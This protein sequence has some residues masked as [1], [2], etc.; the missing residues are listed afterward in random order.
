MKRSILFLTLLALLL[1][2][3]VFAHHAAEG[4]V[5][6]AIWAMIDDNLEGSPHLDLDFDDPGCSADMY[7]CMGTDVQPIDGR[8]YL[9]TTVEV[10]LLSQEARQD[11]ATYIESS[12]E[13]AF[14]DAI[15]AIRQ[16]PSGT[17]GDDTDRVFYDPDYFD[18]DNDGSY[19][20][21][22]V[23]LYEPIGSGHSSESITQPD[24]P[25]PGNRKGG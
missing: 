16:I 18:T 12:F 2:A 3:S 4:I 21:A 6:D 8:L 25:Q 14:V 20:Y 15:E 19:E 9:V 10:E 22:I 5:S 24:T 17:L 23:D 11:P 1:P 13:Q 7:S